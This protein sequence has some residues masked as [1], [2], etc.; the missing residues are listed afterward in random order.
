LA[1]GRFPFARQGCFDHAGKDAGKRL[2]FM[3]L[4]DQYVIKHPCSYEKG[5][6]IDSDFF[7]TGFF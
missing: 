5:R 1:E 4:L 3:N 7:S 2:L 6:D